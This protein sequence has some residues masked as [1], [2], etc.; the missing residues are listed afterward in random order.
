PAD[1]MFA[2]CHAHPDH[3]PTFVARNVPVLTTRNLDAADRRLHP[4]VIRLLDEFGD[5]DDV[6][7][8]LSDN[9]RTFGWSGSMTTYYAL[10]EDP[11]REIENHPSSDV[12]RWSKAMRAQFKKDISAARDEDEEQ[13][14]SWET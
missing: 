5:R 2:W 13:A 8:A 6:R 9:M 3:G 7:R 10:Y 4:I 14:A 1:M 11:L 12:R